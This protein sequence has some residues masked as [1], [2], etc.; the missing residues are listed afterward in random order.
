MDETY[1]YLFDKIGEIPRIQLCRGGP[2][3]LPYRVQHPRYAFHINCAYPPELSDV[4]GQALLNLVRDDAAAVL[5]TVVRHAKLKAFYS[6]V[7]TFFFVT[8][9]G[10]DNIRIYRVSGMASDLYKAKHEDPETLLR[11]Y[12][13]SETS[14][15]DK[16]ESLLQSYSP[17]D[18]DQVF[19]RVPDFGTIPSYVARQ[20][21][22]VDRIIPLQKRSQ[23]IGEQFFTNI[24]R[25]L[26]R[27]IQ[28]FMCA[29][30]KR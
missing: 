3:P 28:K 15:L 11:K 6:I 14:G 20:A 2:V 10:Y 26:V 17:A 19:R 25:L 4:D 7:V 27:S 16:V 8:R 23:F 12:M 29:W 5:S 13:R 22:A 1:D 30:R 9:D 18:A 24:G 21:V